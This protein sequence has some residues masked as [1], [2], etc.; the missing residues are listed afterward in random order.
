M[1]A[2]FASALQPLHP[3]TQ[4]R[5]NLSLAP[6]ETIDHLSEPMEFLQFVE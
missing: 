6:L 2:S 3:I 5:N 4:P 1:A